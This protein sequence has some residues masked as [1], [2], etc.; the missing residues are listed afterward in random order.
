MNE[1]ETTPKNEEAD[2]SEVRGYFTPVPIPAAGQPVLRT[3]LRAAP[4]ALTL[5]RTTLAN[6]AG[7]ANNPRPTP[8]GV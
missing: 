7:P 8:I 5:P 1:H 2:D 3:S 6:A 4:A